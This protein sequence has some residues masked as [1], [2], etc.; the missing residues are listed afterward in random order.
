M[1]INNNYYNNE[2]Q[3]S[4]KKIFMILLTTELPQIFQ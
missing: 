2:G 4:L 3:K 1:K